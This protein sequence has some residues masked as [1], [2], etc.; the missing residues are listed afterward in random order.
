MQEERLPFC[1]TWTS[2]VGHSS[3][4]STS[5]SPIGLKG[6]IGY[7]APEYAQTGQASTNGDV[8]SFGIVLLE[9]LIGKRPTDPMFDNELNI[10]NFAER[11]S[12]DQI[13]EIIDA[14]LQEECKGFI[15]ASAEAGDLVYQCL[16]S[17]V[18]V[19]LSC[20]RLSPRERMNMREVAIAR[21]QNIIYMLEQ[22]S[23][24]KLCHARVIW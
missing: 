18:Q 17:L 4:A 14:H 3:S 13:L 16:V 12:P 19:A 24:S 5:D 8:F 7:I 2:K 23:E 10:V 6:T 15:G 20:T 11:N 21:S 9:M 1:A 22:P